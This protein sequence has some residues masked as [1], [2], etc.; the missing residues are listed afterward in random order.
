MARPTAQTLKAQQY[1]GRVG[2]LR[3]HALHGPAVMLG[4]ARRGFH[5]RFR[6]L[7]DPEGL[8]EPGER[9]LRA[10][11]LRRA[12][13]LALA[14]KSAEARRNR[15]AGVSGEAGAQKNRSRAGDR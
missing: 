6:R 14:A 7:V 9:E 8:L 3:A 15:A 12:H 5:D 4:P 11:R 2:G 10:D 13:M 1:W